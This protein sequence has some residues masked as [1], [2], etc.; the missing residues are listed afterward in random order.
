MKLTVNGVEHEIDVDPRTLLVHAI[1]EQVGLTGT[2][3]GC[4]TGDCGACTVVVDGQTTKSCSVLALSAEG[5]AVET[6]ESLADGDDL[7]PVQQAFWDEFGFQCGFCLPGMLLTAKELVES[8]PDPTD[9]DILRAI[10]GNLC[11]C[12]GYNTI[13]AAV[14]KAARS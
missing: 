10:D 5:S 8:T 7:H 1:R 4:L 11:R 6:I 2:H 12:T 9:D 3:V 14:R 13:V